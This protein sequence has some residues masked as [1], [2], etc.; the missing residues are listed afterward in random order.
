MLKTW[1]VATKDDD[2]AQGLRRIRIQGW[3]RDGAVAAMEYRV[4]GDVGWHPVARESNVDPSRPVFAVD[5]MQEK[6]YEFRAVDDSG[7]IGDVLLVQV[8]RRGEEL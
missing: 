7:N 1:P 5:G 8:P 4:V 3:D 6:R 2:K